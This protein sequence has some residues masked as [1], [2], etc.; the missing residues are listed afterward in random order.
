MRGDLAELPDPTKP[1]EEL[2][3]QV[4]DAMTERNLSQNALCGVLVPVP[5]DRE[6][7]KERGPQAG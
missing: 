6:A 7:K 1:A 3:T 5:D 2:A 4:Q